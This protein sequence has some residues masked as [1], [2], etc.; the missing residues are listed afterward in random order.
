MMPA[1]RMVCLELEAFRGFAE[2]QVLDL[3]AETVLV[4]GDNGTGKTSIADGLLWLMTGQVPRLRERGK[5]MRK[6][7]AD[8]IVSRYR[9]GEKAR[10]SLA[11]RITSVN[12]GEGADPEEVT[13]ERVGDNGHSTLSA[14]RGEEKLSGTDAER[15]LAGSFGD[16]TTEQFSHAVSAWGVLQQHALLQALEGGASM[17]ERLAEMVGLERVNRFAASAAEVAKRARAEQRRAEQVRDQLRQK[18]EIAASRLKRGTGGSDGIGAEPS[19]D[20]EADRQKHA[21]STAGFG[22]RAISGGFGGFPRTATGA[23]VARGSGA[24]PGLCG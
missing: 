11:V 1:T 5:G 7:G 12:G 14:R 22:I 15:L 10:V 4:W 21:R 24:R 3:D 8:P 2:K 18:R 13:F 16:F 23:R 19:V 17:H 9:P 6:E 20:F